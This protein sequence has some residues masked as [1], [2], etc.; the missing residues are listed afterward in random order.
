[1]RAEVPLDDG[2]DLSGRL[3]EVFAGMSQALMQLHGEEA[4]KQSKIPDEDKREYPVDDALN[5][6]ALLDEAGWPHSE[7]TTGRLAAE[8]ETRGDYY[9]AIIEAKPKG[10][11]LISAELMRAESLSD[12]GRDALAALL[13]RASAIVRMASASAGE[14]DDGYHAQFEIYFPSTP[15]VVELGHSL[16]AL[17]VACALCGREA[18]ALEHEPI[19]R[20]YLARQAWFS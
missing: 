10:G 19:A 11:I 3:H 4:G 13:L 12:Q 7:R 17:S 1:L 14:S 9:Q 2:I 20:E 16:S 15:A 18:R 8:L 6:S 5:L